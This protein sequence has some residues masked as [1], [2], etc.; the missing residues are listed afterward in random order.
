MSCKPAAKLRIL[1]ACRVPRR[2]ALTR[3]RLT[4]FDR[5]RSSMSPNTSMW[6][7]DAR[8]WTRWSANCC[9]RAGPLMERLPHAG[10]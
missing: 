5:S 2:G 6:S 3:P 8:M 1:H 9:S 4:W 10:G 7:A